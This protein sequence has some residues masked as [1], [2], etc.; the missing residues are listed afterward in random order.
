MTELRI[1][2]DDS[3]TTFAC[4]S[5]CQFICKPARSP[6]AQPTAW[7]APR[8]YRSLSF[9]GAGMQRKHFSSHR[10][11]CFSRSFTAGL[12]LLVSRF[13]DEASPSRSSMG[14]LTARKDNADL[15]L[16]PSWINPFIA[17]KWCIRPVQPT[18][19]TAAAVI[20]LELQPPFW[21]S[22]KTWASGGEDAA[23]LIYRKR[24]CCQGS[25][26]TGI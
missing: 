18:K 2:W 4:K 3:V 10:M 11:D 6:H 22:G 12:F 15:I 14:A 23:Y 8:A 21:S 26:I 17:P 20:R 5:G 9:I 25:G 7:P 19:L 16:N 24:D 1:L 13:S